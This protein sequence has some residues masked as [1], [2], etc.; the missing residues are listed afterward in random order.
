MILVPG[1]SDPRGTDTKGEWNMALLGYK[2]INT[3]NGIR[4]GLL[5]AARGSDGRIFGVT[6]SI[7]TIGEV[8]FAHV[9]DASYDGN[10]AER[11]EALR[12][13]A[14]PMSA[15]RVRKYERGAYQQTFTNSPSID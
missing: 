8:S 7:E 10:A 2:T 9:R 4:R 15:V 11:L 12:G 5:S 1:V 14:C 6:L 13:S 3:A